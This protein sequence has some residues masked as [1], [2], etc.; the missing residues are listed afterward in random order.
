[1]SQQQY[2]DDPD[3][4]AALA[5]IAAQEE[6]ER[7]AQQAAVDAAAQAQTATVPQTP[8][9]DP[10]IDQAAVIFD[11]RDQATDKI[12]ERYSKLGDGSEAAT[13]V[14]TEIRAV[15][16]QSTFEAAKGGETVETIMARTE[17]IENLEALT[18]GKLTKAGA[19][20]S[21]R[22]SLDHMPTDVGVGS[23]PTDASGMIAGLNE[24]YGSRKVS[25]AV[26]T[27]RKSLGDN[28]QLS[29]HDIEAF[30]R[31]PKR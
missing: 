6:R 21:E 8:P 28:V 20:K 16:R 10:G 29:T 1:M 3:V 13:K 15:V 19:I 12:M 30:I 26:S 4:Q 23:T 11:I 7:L 9:P 18:I 22:R 14:L 27:L 31:A 2:S 24:E 5:E 17:G 25:E